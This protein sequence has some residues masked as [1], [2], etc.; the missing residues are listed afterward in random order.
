MKEIWNEYRSLVRIFKDNITKFLKYQIATKI[1]IAIILLPLFGWISNT[2]MKSAGLSYITNGLI[3]K[4]VLSPQG[5]IFILLGVIFAIIVVLIELGGLIVLSYQAILREK[6]EYSYFQ[7]IK[8]SLSKSKYL[9]GINGILITFYL[10]LIGPLYGNIITTSVVNI[11]V[12]G[13]IMDVIQSKTSYIAYLVVV[14]IVIVILSIRWMFSL[15]IIM[16][17][18]KVKNSLKESARLVKGN[19]RYILKYTLGTGLL[20]IITVGASILIYALISTLIL[21]PISG[22]YYEIVFILLLCIGGVFIFGALFF[23]IPIEILKLTK[24]YFHLQGHDVILDIKIRDKDNIIDKVITNKKV[25][26]LVFVICVTALS[27]YSFMILDGL[28][29]AKYDIDITAH[30]GS[31]KLAPENTISALKVAIKN[32]AT[33]AEI[34]VQ[35]TKDGQVILLHDNTF[36]RTVGTDEMP[37]QMTLEEIKQLDT[38]ILFDSKFK[39][40]KV[41]TLQEVIDYAK[42]KIKLNI[43]LKT[44]K[45]DK[46]LIKKVT[47]IIKEK[48]FI[49]SCVVTSLDYNAL[50][51]IKRQEHLIKTGYIMYFAVGELEKLKVDFY[52]IEETN[53]NEGFVSTA[54]SIGREVHVWT[55][56]TETSM[57]NMIELG[58]D[59]IITDNDSMLKE[60]LDSYKEE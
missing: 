25:I 45:S 1:L 44:N 13:F 22:Q 30:R 29:N 9:I 28:D 54:H 14:T 20:N 21:L 11:K 26:V 8:Y 4:F 39:G 36:K 59:N 18:K 56:N 47:K 16:L 35:E 6:Q 24:L 2:L 37:S 41:P 7:V 38:G 40:E 43:E 31:S 10:F 51:E 52:S 34:D 50:L 32:G 58:V 17:K 3:K 19:L 42:G 46:V 23:L 12:P 53:V 33:Y 60:L 48:N 5:I 57:E 49:K 55:I 27:V 15:H